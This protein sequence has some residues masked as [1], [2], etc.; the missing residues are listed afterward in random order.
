MIRLPFINVSVV[1]MQ[2]YLY[3]YQYHFSSQIQHLNS[4]LQIVYF[5]CEVKSECQLFIIIEHFRPCENMHKHVFA[6]QNTQQFLTKLLF[7]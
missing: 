2:L 4:K 7:S 1:L 5:L 6:G 3:Y